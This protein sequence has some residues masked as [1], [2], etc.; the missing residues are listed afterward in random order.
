MINLIIALLS[1]L[2]HYLLHP[3]NWKTQA[4]IRQN[5]TVKSEISLTKEQLK[6]IGT[7]Y[8]NAF[9]SFRASND[10]TNCHFVRVDVRIITLDKLNDSYYFFDV[11]KNNVFLGR[12]YSMSK[13][14]YITTALSD[15]TLKH[16]FLHYLFDDCG[17]KMSD[18]DEH[19]QIY[20]LLDKMK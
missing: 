17:F 13:V 10:T 9:D 19:K 14:I 20:K 11:N 8:V 16:E 18:N 3:I 6:E 5:I 12:Y 4:Q 2:P 15:R 1:I 7:A